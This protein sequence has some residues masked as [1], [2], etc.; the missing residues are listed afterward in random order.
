[1]T[2]QVAMADSK[3]VVSTGFTESAVERRVFIAGVQRR[4]YHSNGQAIIFCSCGYYLSCSSSFLFFSSPILS[5]WRLDIYHTSTH[6]VAL[7]RI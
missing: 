6:D 3:Q 1:M 2:A 5:S 4:P 7:V